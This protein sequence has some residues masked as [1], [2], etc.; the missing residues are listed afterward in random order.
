MIPHLILSSGPAYAEWVSVA[1][2]NQ[3][4]STVYVD[5]GTIRRKGDLVKMWH[6]F[7]NKTAETYRANSVLSIKGQ[8]QYDCA[9]ERTRVLRIRSFLAI[10]EAGQWFTPTQTKASGNQLHQTVL[11]KSCGKLGATRT[12]R[13]AAR[14]PLRRH[15]H[16]KTPTATHETMRNHVIPGTTKASNLMKS[17]QEECAT[18]EPPQTFNPAAFREACNLVLALALIYN[19]CKNTTCCSPAQ[20]FQACGGA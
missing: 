15:G 18:L 12:D 4:G 3:A 8:N 5:P 17:F 20:E 1:K 2:S 19:D 7:D 14:N 9:D 16:A 10:W 6:L 11:L 13:A